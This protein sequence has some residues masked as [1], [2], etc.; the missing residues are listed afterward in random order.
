MRIEHIGDATIMLGDCMEAMREMPDKS[1]QVCVTSPPYFGLRDYGVNGQIGQERTPEEYTQKLVNVFSEVRR[2]LRDD[3]TLWL[4]LGDS[5]A[6]S[7]GNY[8]GKNR[9]SGKQR[10]IKNG[11]RAHQ[12]AYDGLENWRPPTSNKIKGLK[13]KDIIGIPWRVA[14][15]LQADGWYL[16]QDIIWAKPNPMP[17]S[18]TDRCTKSH[19]YIFLLSKSAHYFYNQQAIAEPVSES[20]IERGPVDFG[21]EK[22]RDYKKN[23]SSDDPN[24]RSGSEQW[25]R[26][27]DYNE[28]HKSWHNSQFHTGKT[29]EHQLGRSQKN[30]N[31]EAALN[32]GNGSGFRGH[33]GNTRADGTLFSPDGLRNKRSVWTITTSPYKKAHFATYPRELVQP[34]ILAGSSEGDT[35]LDPFGGSGTTAAVA[36]SLGRKATTCE[37]NPDYAELIKDRIK[38]EEAY[39]QPRLFDEPRPNLPQPQDLPL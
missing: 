2:V 9:G 13:P 18:V 4:N 10:E 33:S 14:F 15:A 36:L 28:S 16:R 17:E 38:S 37:L 31:P 39:Q 6:G 30:R 35:V 11:S 8:G 32:G 29:G 26:T 34:C 23:I 5:Y 21:G 19:E 22:G 25:G 1:V 20:T 7:W 24:Y 12:E 3:G 27:Y